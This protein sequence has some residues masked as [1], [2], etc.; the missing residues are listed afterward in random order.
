[1]Q[2]IVESSLTELTSHVMLSSTGVM[3]LMVFA[4]FANA[5]TPGT[6]VFGNVMALLSFD[7]VC[8][9]LFGICCPTSPKF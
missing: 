3:N 1:M 6:I 9:Q 5:L 8:R 7:A 4:P 2:V